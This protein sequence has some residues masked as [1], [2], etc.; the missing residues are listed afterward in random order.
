VVFVHARDVG[1]E[2]LA[3]YGQVSNVVTAQLRVKAYSVDQRRPLGS[4]WSDAVHF[5]SLNAADQTDETVKP[6][7]Q[8]IAQSLQAY[9]PHHDRG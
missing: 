5:S 7:L 3:A 2:Q 6:W 8:E 9:H 1:A 4:D